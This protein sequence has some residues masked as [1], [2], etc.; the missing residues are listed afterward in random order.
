MYPRP[1]RQHARRRSGG[2]TSVV[3]RRQ[4]GVDR[5]PG[6]PSSIRNSGGAEDN[7]FRCPTSSGCP[8]TRQGEMSRRKTAADDRTCRRIFDSAGRPN[9]ESRRLLRRRARSRLPRGQ[10]AGRIARTRKVSPSRVSGPS[11][12]PSGFANVSRLSETL[13]APSLDEEIGQIAKT[14]NQ[15]LDPVVSRDRLRGLDFRQAP[16]R[17]V[18]R[19]EDLSIPARPGCGNDPPRRG[20]AAPEL[21]GRGQNLFSR[22]PDRVQ[23]NP[24]IA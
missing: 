17:N 20:S 5:H 12:D 18:P 1:P 2:K 22:N 4:C 19:H 24:G 6:Q 10:T 11:P 3:T 14:F 15:M 16:A 21:P 13:V 23:R 9:S 8:E 7:N